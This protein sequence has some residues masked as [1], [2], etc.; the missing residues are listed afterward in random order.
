MRRNIA[1]L[2]VLFFALSLTLP[3]LSAPFGDV[4]EDHWAA[5]AVSQLAAKGLVE[6]YPDGLY[7][8]DRA[9][10]RYEMAMVVS[11]VMAKLEQ[12][13][14]HEHEQYVTKKDLEM[15]KKLMNE[16]KDEL[17]ALGIRVSNAE[18]AIASLEKRVTELERV[19]VYGEFGTRWVSASANYDTDRVTGTTLGQPGA[20]ALEAGVDNVILRRKTW[21]LD[22]FSY[23]PYVF[24]RLSTG[25]AFTASGTIGVTGKLAKNID[26]GAEISAW[27]ATGDRNNAV[28][29]GTR[30][31]YLSNPFT[32]NSSFGATGNLKDNAF[33]FRAALDNVWARKEAWKLTLGT[34]RPDRVKDYFLTGAPNLQWME[35]GFYYPLWGAQLKGKWKA[36]EYPMWGEG[37]IAKLPEQGGTSGNVNTYLFG[38]HWDMNFSSDKANFGVNWQRV[39]NTDTNTATATTASINRPLGGATAL[40]A[41]GNHIPWTTNGT[42]FNAGGVSVTPQNQEMDMWGADLTYKV[43]EF[44]SKYFKNFWLQV[45]WGHSSYR[46]T[47]VVPTG[48]TSVPDASGNLWSALLAAKVFNVD[49]KGEYLS[50]DPTYAPFVIQF[51]NPFGLFTGPGTGFAWHQQSPYSAYFNPGGANTAGYYTVNSAVNYPQN[52]Q[53]YRLTG[54]WDFDLWKSKGT[55]YSAWMSFDQRQA[56]NAANISRVGFTE[57]HFTLP[58]TSTGTNTKGELQNWHNGLRYDI[59]LPWTDNRL[60][61]ELWHWFSHQRRATTD[62]NNVFVQWNRWGTKVTYPFSKKVSVYAGYASESRTL[63]VNNRNV[64]GK[65]DQAPVWLGGFWYNLTDKAS[66]YLEGMTFRKQKDANTITGLTLGE[67]GNTF[68]YDGVFIHSGF[69]MK[70]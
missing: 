51:T 64:T 45:K 63:T 22:P 36:G 1:W 3:A 2:I 59:V 52:R 70:F 65:F 50:V 11:R 34:Y 43:P 61:W 58:A 8:G 24:P 35:P 54:S 15:V 4:P 32:E 38:A 25:T 19:R 10:S 40:S 13:A 39:L 60:T 41:D 6:G 33:N 49:L 47:T 66:W 9:A 27:S 44:D 62:V 29:W 14:K 28:R 53:G 26:G 7:R 48:A 21:A 5:E 16:Y 69:N 17:D 42:P 46:P 67:N 12:L 57:P 30:Q 23:K 55:L 18:A 37:Y 56:T 31:P 68:S 20:A